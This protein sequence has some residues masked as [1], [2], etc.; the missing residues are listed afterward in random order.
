MQNIPIEKYFDKVSQ[1]YESISSVLECCSN[2]LRLIT[3]CENI[4]HFWACGPDRWNLILW[5][6]KV[7]HS[8]Y[9][10]NSDNERWYE[11]K[12]SFS[13]LRVVYTKFR[14]LRW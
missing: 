4:A 7:L 12:T 8:K 6:L 11:R 13:I 2:W 10:A 9:Q 5:D 1:G 3:L 14:S